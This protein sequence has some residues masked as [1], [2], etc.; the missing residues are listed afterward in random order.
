MSNPFSFFLGHNHQIKKKKYKQKSP[1]QHQTLNKAPK[2]TTLN[3]IA[4][5][6]EG[7]VHVEDTIACK[8]VT[9]DSP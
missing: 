2:S 9:R 3:K 4:K 6:G 7:K 8:G 1:H 5:V